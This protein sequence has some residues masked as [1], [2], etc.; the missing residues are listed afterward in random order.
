MKKISLLLLPTMLLT[1]CNSKG[2]LRIVSPTGAPAIAFYNYSTSDSFQTNSDPSNIIPMMLNK[3]VDIAVLPTNAGIQ[4]IT[5][6]KVDYK[7]AATITFGNI[8]IGATGND[9]DGIMDADDYI[10]S[11]QKGAVPDKIFHYVYGD[12]LDNALHYV[13]NGQEAAKCL[14]TGKNLA[15]NETV[16][17]VVL[18]EPA[19]T[20]VISTTDG[21]TV[22]A[23][24]QELY[25]VKSGNL[26]IFQA[27]LFVSNKLERNIVDSF[28]SSLEK[29]IN[30]GLANPEL[31][32]KGL[33][34]NSAAEVLYGIKPEQ[35][36][37][38]TANNNG[39]GLGFALAK[40][41]KEAIDLFLSL[42]GIGAT[43]EEIYY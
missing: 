16:D 5:G 15:D 12:S 18:A 2:E 26:Q 22:Y 27:S 7:I 25:K 10:V 29:D 36:K 41:N 20:S 21:R 34:A 28:L 40:D 11:F 17:Y 6:K 32:Q 42:F 35:A 39:M 3:T 24:L 8:F 19:L 38:V 37:A 43:N 1:G 31:I 33:S 30:D 23:N 14:K 9:D 4:A 13:S